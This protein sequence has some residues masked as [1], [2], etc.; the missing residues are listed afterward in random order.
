VLLLGVFIYLVNKNKTDKGLKSFDPYEILGIEGGS[1]DIEIRKAYKNLAKIHH[2]DRNHNDPN[3]HKT[4]IILSK[5][6]N[7]IKDT[8]A[9]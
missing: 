4:F 9:R 6:Y 8:K 7:C 1:S 5:A 2:P 3:A